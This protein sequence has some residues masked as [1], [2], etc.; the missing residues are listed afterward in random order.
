M[1]RD[2]GDM[3]YD[4]I[5]IGAG[6]AGAIVASRMTEDPSKHVLLLEAGPDYPD[7]ERMPD[8]IRYGYI[9]AADVKPS[10]HDWRFTGR[11]TDKNPSMVVPRGKVTGGSSAI[12]GQFYLRGIPEDFERWASWGNTEWGFEKV[13]AYFRKLETDMDFPGDFHGSNGPVF[14]RR[15][16]PDEWLPDQRAFYESCRALGFP[17]SPDHNQPDAAGVGPL[18]INN[19]NGI[20]W[21]TA[22]AYLD[23]AR[24]RLNLTIKPNCLV[25]RI[26]FDGN[27]AIGVEV[28]SGGELFSV[29]GEEIILSA[30]PVGSPHI[31]M[32]SGVGPAEDLKGV[33]IPVVKDVPGVGQNL[34]DHPIIGVVWSTKPGHQ[35]DPH[36]PRFQMILRYT[37]TGSQLRNDMQLVMVSLATDN[38]YQGGDYLEPVGI[39]MS[40]VLNL[41]AGQGEIRLTSADPHQQPFLD[42]N[43]FKDEFDLRRVREGVRL[44]VRIGEQGAFRDIIAGRIRPSDEALASDDAMDD[45]ILSNVSTCH[46]ISGTCKMGPASDPAA[47]VDQYGRLHGMEGLR[48]ADASVMPDCIRANTNLTTMMIGER[49][50]DFIINGS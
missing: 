18:P 9:T 31:L 24:H 14:A 46:H 10:D 49:M 43:Y 34:R 42:Y 5:V 36:G 48:V 19:V 13:L 45:W 40:T 26:L 4:Y 30:G 2:G 3:K 32:L 7:I 8:D 27:R 28:E 37:A 20:R 47:V 39:S 41:A 6:S 21:S 44:C 15:F 12:N 1:L 17:D 29:Y 23:P 11:A 16:K 35:F 50:A 33:G 25:R 22:I 38:I